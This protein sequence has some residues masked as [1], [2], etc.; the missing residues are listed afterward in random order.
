MLESY[1]NPLGVDGG[2]YFEERF[3]ARLAL[4]INQPVKISYAIERLIKWQKEQKEQR[5]KK[6]K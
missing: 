6:I 5:E 4:I 3:T 1:D 2:E